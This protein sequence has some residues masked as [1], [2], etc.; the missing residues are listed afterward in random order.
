AA[1]AWL[2]DGGGGPLADDLVELHHALADEVA[3]HRPSDEQLR[4]AHVS[5]E[6]DIELDMR[7]SIGQRVEVVRAV[8][9]G[10]A[11]V[12]EQRELVRLAHADDL[13]D[14]LG[15]LAVV[16]VVLGALHGAPRPRLYVDV[17]RGQDALERAR[18]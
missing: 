9:L 17:R 8:R 11:P 1:V 6:L 14:R 10:T 12:H 2:R 7:A 18:I 3:P 5:A 13:E 4:S 16:A 15:A